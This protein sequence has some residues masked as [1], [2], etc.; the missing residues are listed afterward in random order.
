[1]HSRAL[2]LKKHE[3]GKGYLPNSIAINAHNINFVHLK[4]IINE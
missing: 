4:L 2:T 3:I 1:L